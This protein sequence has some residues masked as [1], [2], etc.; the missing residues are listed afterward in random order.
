M[1]FFSSLATVL[2]GIEE[3]ERVNRSSSLLWAIQ[4]GMSHEQRN[5]PRDGG[6]RIRV[7]TDNA[8]NRTSRAGLA[9]VLALGAGSATA[10]TDSPRSN[11]F[12]DQNETSENDKSVP[13]TW[14][15]YPRASCHAG[16]QSTVDE[17]G[18]GQFYPM[19]ELAPI[20]DQFVPGYSRD[21][22]YS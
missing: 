15:N 7:T 19:R 5:T 17:G 6:T 16:F 4:R 22:L 12:E 3:C 21:F 18:F 14:E 11:V 1:K 9:G 8:P 10:Q 20:E 13:V 2:Y